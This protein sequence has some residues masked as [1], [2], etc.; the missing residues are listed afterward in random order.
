MSRIDDIKNY[1]HKCDSEKVNKEIE[2]QNKIEIYKEQIRT[3]KPRIEE[4]LEVGN[5]CNENGIEL[6]GREWGGREGYDTHQFMTNSWSHLLGFVGN[7]NSNITC[8]G[9]Y[10]GGA[11]NYHLET[12][13]D[14]IEVSGDILY[15]LKRFI[16]E[17]DR[18]EA[19]FYK[20]VDEIISK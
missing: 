3:L 20:Y 7:K 1:K 2:K 9:I 17:F 8:L 15:I 14:F 5:A 18:F 4:L 10:G 16:D 13:G 6:T 11:C 19:E 12:N